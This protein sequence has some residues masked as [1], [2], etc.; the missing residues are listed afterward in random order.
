VEWRRKERDRACDGNRRRRRGDQ[1]LAAAV[2]APVLGRCV[3]RDL[4]FT[5]SPQFIVP[6][7]EPDCMFESPPAH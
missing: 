4:R 2:S 3:S 7:R 1:L 6:T 5:L